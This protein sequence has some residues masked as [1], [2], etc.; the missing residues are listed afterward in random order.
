MKD[1]VQEVLDQVRPGLQGD[2]GDV[3]LVEVTDDG[4]VKVELEGSCKGCPFSQLTVKNFIEKT[5]K[6][7]IPEV[8]EVVSVN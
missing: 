6:E 2:G 5:L 7:Q 1:K 3:R 8:K 4:I